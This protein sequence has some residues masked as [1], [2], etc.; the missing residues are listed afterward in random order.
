MDSA[1]LPLAAGEYTVS[2]TKGDAPKKPNVVFVT[3]NSSTDIGSYIYAVPGK[4]DVFTAVLQGSAD[5]RVQ[6]VATRI[7]TLLVKKSGCPS[8]V[9]VSGAVSEMDEMDRW[10]HGIRLVESTLYAKQAA[11]R[12]LED[13]TLE[14]IK[15]MTIYSS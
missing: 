2:V 6:D 5:S 12:L 14:L 10:L 11:E 4:K 7:G 9:C 15:S 13:E 8:Y 3:E 1:V